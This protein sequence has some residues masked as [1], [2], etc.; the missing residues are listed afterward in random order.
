[1]FSKT[2]NVQIRLYYTLGGPGIN[3]RSLLRVIGWPVGL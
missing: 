2:V 1:M 3:I